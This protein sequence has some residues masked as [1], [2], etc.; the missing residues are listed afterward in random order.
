MLSGPP[1][2]FSLPGTLFFLCHHFQ[3]S[4]PT[5]LAPPEQPPISTQLEGEIT[6][7]C[8]LD[9]SS[10]KHSHQVPQGEWA[11]GTQ[12]DSWVGNTALTGCIVFLTIQRLFHFLSKGLALDSLPWGVL[13]ES[14]G[15]KTQ[16]P[17]LQ[18]PSGREKRIPRVQTLGRALSR[19]WAE[20]ARREWAGNCVTFG[21]CYISWRGFFHC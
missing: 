12:R 3:M 11:A 10:Q 13:V 15:V 14:T 6:Q 21:R 20:G 16:V 1:N 9:M 17:F 7:T 18:G 5:S 2:I 8:G 4:A 19:V